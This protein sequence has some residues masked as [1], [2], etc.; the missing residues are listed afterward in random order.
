MCRNSDCLD[1]VARLRQ[2]IRR[3]R[4]RLADTW[5]QNGSPM[6]IRRLEGLIRHRWRMIEVARED[7][8]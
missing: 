7:C 6:A 1:T 3:L 2:Q 5:Q 4:N 8:F